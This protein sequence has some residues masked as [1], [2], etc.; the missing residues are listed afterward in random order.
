LRRR[1]EGIVSIH[2]RDSCSLIG[3]RRDRFAHVR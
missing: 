2:L 1:G 3:V